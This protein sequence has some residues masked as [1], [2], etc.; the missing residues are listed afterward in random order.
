MDN[1]DG[2]IRA[3][4][5]TFLESQV[6]ISFTLGHIATKSKLGLASVRKSIATLEEQGVV[7][8]V[9]GQAH[10]RFYIPTAEQ[11]AAM[12]KEIVSHWRPLKPRKQLADRIAS[13]R[14][15]RAAIPS[16]I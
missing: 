16:R 8:R 5:I 2:L 13:I 7:R 11:L 10:A 14:A 3:G 6:G 1:V 12:Q 9:T 4:I 15:E